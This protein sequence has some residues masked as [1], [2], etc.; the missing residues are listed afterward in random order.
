MDEAPDHGV[1]IVSPRAAHEEVAEQSRRV[2]PSAPE[3]AEP[4]AEWARPRGVEQG[5]ANP[6][7]HDR[8]RERKV[9][10]GEPADDENHVGR[11]CRDQRLGEHEAR[12]HE[13]QDDRLPPFDH[14]VE[15]RVAEQPPLPRRRRLDRAEQPKRVQHHEERRDAAQRVERGEPGGSGLA[16]AGISRASGKFSVYRTSA[17]S[18]ASKR[19]LPSGPAASTPFERRR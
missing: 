18:S 3:P 7:Q 10:A 4:G 19:N 9:N 13:E 17:P 1:E 11:R 16:H 6:G 8:R 14:D 5:V 15:R 12:E 2:V